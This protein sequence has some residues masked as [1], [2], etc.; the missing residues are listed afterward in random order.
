MAKIKVT[1]ACAIYD[2]MSMT[3]KTPCDC[4]AVDGLNVYF[5]GIGQTFSFRD[6][7]GAPLAGIDNLFAE[8]AYVKVVLDTT[9]QYAYIQNAAT[10]KYLEDKFAALSKV[11]PEPETE[12]VAVSAIDFSSWDDGIFGV[13]M[14]DNSEKDGTVRFDS[15]G[16]PFAITL[17]GHT[18]YITWPKGDEA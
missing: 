13:L 2:G 7:N 3:L 14:A 18:V 9:N 11:D 1:S 17:D 15:S 12:E 10:N 5:S 8:G 16:N 4:T 6:A